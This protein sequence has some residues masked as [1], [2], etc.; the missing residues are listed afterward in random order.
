M[1]RTFRILRT[2]FIQWWWYSAIY[3][4]LWDTTEG[5]YAYVKYDTLPWRLL[6]KFRFFIR[7]F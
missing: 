3:E 4:W 7:G 2:R 1:F 5:W 6:R